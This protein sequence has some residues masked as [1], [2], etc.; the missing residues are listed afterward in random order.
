MDNEF[1][2][3]QIIEYL[4]DENVEVRFTKPNNHT[5]NAERDSIQL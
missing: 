1:K 2:S 5:G 4:R 3:Q